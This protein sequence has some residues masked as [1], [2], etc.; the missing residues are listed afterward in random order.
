MSKNWVSNFLRQGSP[1]VEIQ[2]TKEDLLAQKRAWKNVKRLVTAGEAIL[3]SSAF[4]SIITM[5]P[6]ELDG[7][8]LEVLLTAATAGCDKLRKYVQT[9]IKEID[10][11]LE[12]EN[13][14]IDSPSTTCLPQYHDELCDER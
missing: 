2:V 6:V 7:P 10:Q 13:N 1:G 4:L 5:L 12:T 9:K 14:I 11:K 8:I 3:G